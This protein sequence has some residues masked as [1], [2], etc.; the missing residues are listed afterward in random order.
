MNV[1]RIMIPGIMLLI[2][3]LVNA[4]KSFEPSTF[5]GFHGGVN[6]SSVNFKP[7]RTQ[8]LLMSNQAGFIF[9]HVSE[10]S[11]GFQLEVNYAGKGWKE[12]TDTT[13]TY[14]RK[15]TTLDVPVNAV[16]I[17]GSRL[18]QVAFNLGPYGSYLLNE[19]EIIHKDAEDMES[20]YGVELESKWE[21]GFN[22]GAAIEFHTGVGVFA[23]RGGYSHALTNLFP[24]NVDDYYFSA[25]RN[26]VINVGLVYMYQF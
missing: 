4:Q 22:V 14:T 23:L 20:Y 25:S 6:L 9:R 5:V 24:L 7:S 13:G 10:K 17:A 26:Q 8:K 2:S 18:F 12:D 21:F 11:I 19:K 16:F 1:K 3:L 15:L